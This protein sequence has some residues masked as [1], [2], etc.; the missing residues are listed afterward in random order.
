MFNTT[1]P[2][3]LVNE[4]YVEIGG[5][6][7]AVASSY[8][9]MNRTGPGAEHTGPDTPLMRRVHA[10]KELGVVF[11]LGSS[12]PQGYEHFGYPTY[13]QMDAETVSDAHEYLSALV[14]LEPLIDS[15]MPNERTLYE[16]PGNKRRLTMLLRTGGRA[17]AGPH[18]LASTCVLDRDVLNDH[19]SKSPTLQRYHVCRPGTG[20]FN[21]GL[22]GDSMPI[23]TTSISTT[24]RSVS[25]S[26]L[27]SPGPWPG[28][29]P[30]PVGHRCNWS[31]ATATTIPDS[32]SRA[33]VAPL[34]DGRIFMV[35][36]QIPTGRDP[37]VLSISHDGLNFS[38]AF[39][40]RHCAHPPCQPRFGG[41][42][43]VPGFQYPA[44]MWRLDAAGGPEI[45]FSYS[46]NKEDIGLSKFPLAVLDE[47]SI[48]L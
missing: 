41:K 30:V 15:G 7:Y 40:L 5:R 27:T 34:P 26:T 18:M 10:A 8:D 32:G 1:G 47:T 16:L 13:L 43:K 48:I 25:H 44:A 3:G 6:R 11:W 28:Y 22:P 14:D 29:H 39:A 20:L 21:A 46:I 2:R 19:A 12:V 45:I 31:A 17:K 42:G 4:P 36:A 24:A 23:N 38:K 37:L 35:G 33:C 9:V